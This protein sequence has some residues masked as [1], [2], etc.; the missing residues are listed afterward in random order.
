MGLTDL[1]TSLYISSNKNKKINTL[2]LPEYL[3]N[4]QV[5]LSGGDLRIKCW[6]Q[7]ALK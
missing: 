2:D 1:S 5:G 3:I 6:I 7:S 4:I